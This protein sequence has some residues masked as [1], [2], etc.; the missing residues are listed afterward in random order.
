[1]A[2]NPLKLDPRQWRPSHEYS[3]NPRN[4]LETA[5]RNSEKLFNISSPSL[6]IQRRAGCDAAELG[7]VRRQPQSPQH[8]PNDQGDLS[9][10]RPAIRMQLVDH[11]SEAPRRIRARPMARAL[12]QRFLPITH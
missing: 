2:T 11:E 5:A 7:G 6:S 9:A 1:M 10:L 3:L 12:E 8:I 4:D